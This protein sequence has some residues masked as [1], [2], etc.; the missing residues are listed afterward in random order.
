M[1]YIQT[2]NL[3]EGYAID[4]RYSDSN[5]TMTFVINKPNTLTITSPANDRDEL[6]HVE[7]TFSRH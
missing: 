7:N 2:S 3:K 1:N 5:G 6:T 4:S